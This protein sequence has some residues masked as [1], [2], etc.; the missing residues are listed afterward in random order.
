[1]KR[2]TA[3]QLA[4]SLGLRRATVFDLKKSFPD[5]APKTLDDVEEWRQFCLGHLVSRKRPRGYWSRQYPGRTD[6]QY[7]FA[8][9]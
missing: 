4:K 5:A 7:Q 3:G 8:S 1:M 2:F 6:S 9:N